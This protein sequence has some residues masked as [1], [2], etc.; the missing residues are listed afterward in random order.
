MVC[1]HPLTRTVHA[2][3]V[4]VHAA[5]EVWLQVNRRGTPVARCTEARLWRESGLVGAHRGK[6]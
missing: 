1:P 3:N 4:G 2:T 6:V 5:R